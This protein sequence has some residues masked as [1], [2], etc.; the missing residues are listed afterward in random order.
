MNST[1]WW[2]RFYVHPLFVLALLA[3][4][5]TGH[6]ERMLVAFAVVL[7]HELSHALVAESYG[8]RVERIEIWPFGGIAKIDGLGSQDPEVEM[9]VAV[10]GPLQN[11]LLAALAWSLQGRVSIPGGPVHEF[12]ALNLGLG[13]LNL[14]PV[15]PL[16]GGRLADVYLSRRIG[17]A[18]AEHMVRSGGL[19]LSR[20]LM[21]VSMLLLAFGRLPI[22]LAIFSAFLYWGARGRQPL[23]T[24]WTL[25]D[26]AIRSA[27]FQRR[28]IWALDDLA[29]RTTTPV[30]QVLE[31][32]RP[33]HYHRIAVLDAELKRVGV[34]YEEDLV[35]GLHREGPSV[36]V[37]KLLSSR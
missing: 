26:L 8:L 32:M 2:R 25:R 10:A 17:H 13:V 5:L 19:W 11:F 9:M 31:V 36:T 37:G 7:M 28:P 12:I 27:R 20:G 4:S 29:V 6:L 3:Y 1:G 35:A 24:Y 18:R 16:D 14:L 22:A 33:L 23:S 15:T 34:L 21:A 30:S